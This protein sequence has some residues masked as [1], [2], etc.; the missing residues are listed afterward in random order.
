[1]SD[2]APSMASFWW[3]MAAAITAGVLLGRFA[4]PEILV[5]MHWVGAAVMIAQIALPLLLCLVM[6]LEKPPPHARRRRRLV[7]GPA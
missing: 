7:K 1:M 5:V 6:F 2:P 3:T 4:T